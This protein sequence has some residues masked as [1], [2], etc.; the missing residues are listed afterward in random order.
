MLFGQEVE[1]KR[2]LGQITRRR[3]TD[4]GTGSPQKHERGGA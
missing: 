2:L 1:A 4:R 3:T